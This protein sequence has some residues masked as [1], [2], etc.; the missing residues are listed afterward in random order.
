[1]S[2]WEAFP[3]KPELTTLFSDHNPKF[4]FIHVLT[5]WVFYSV[6]SRLISHD[7]AYQSGSSFSFF[8]NSK[9]DVKCLQN[10]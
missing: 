3:N 6:V 1:M 10:K 9:Q 4:G 5:P 8:F 2:P 7:P